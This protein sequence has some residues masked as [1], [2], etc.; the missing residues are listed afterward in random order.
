L[1]LIENQ[2]NDGSIGDL[3]FVL[4]CE[5]IIDGSIG[6]AQLILSIGPPKH[7]EGIFSSFV[8]RATE[9]F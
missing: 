4:N 7:V 8:F 6:V 9:S 1:V 3:L 5:K 2:G